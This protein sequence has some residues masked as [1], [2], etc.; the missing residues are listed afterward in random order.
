MTAFSNDQVMANADQ[1]V[2]HCQHSNEPKTYSMI[3][4]GLI[5]VYIQ[6]ATNLKGSNSWINH[7]KAIKKTYSIA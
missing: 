2:Q 5:L 6:S 1:K 4:R 3:G 7:P